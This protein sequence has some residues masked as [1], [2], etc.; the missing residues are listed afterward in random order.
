MEAMPLAW[1]E[2]MACGKAVVA[3][4]TGPG[5]EIIEDGV[6][7]LLCDPYDPKDIADKILTILKDPDLAAR[8][9]R[10]ARKR[11]EEHF[12]PEVIIPKNIAFYEECIERFKR[13][14][15]DR[16]RMFFRRQ[17]G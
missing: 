15:T 5:P 6:S 16:Q 10:N 3:S 9:G 17:L 12:S 11:V 14:E 1:L 13:G 7:G 8:L 2:A 4:K